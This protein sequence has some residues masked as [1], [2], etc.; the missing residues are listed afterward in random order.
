MAGVLG[1][2]IADG[3]RSAG[4]GIGIRSDD[5]AAARRAVEA[6]GGVVTRPVYDDPG[7]AALL[8]PRAG[9]QRAAG[10]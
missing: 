6:A 2:R 5:I 7:R 9:R 3:E 10:L 1:G 4:P 8:F